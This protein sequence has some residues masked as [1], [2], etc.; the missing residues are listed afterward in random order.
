MARVEELTWAVAS[1][2][3]TPSRLALRTSA[4]QAAVPVVAVAATADRVYLAAPSGAVGAIRYRPRACPL[5]RRLIANVPL[6]R[7]DG[8]DPLDDAGASV[9]VPV[10]II[11]ADL[12]TLASC[13]VSDDIVFNAT[14]PGSWP[15]GPDLADFIMEAVP[16]LGLDADAD[17]L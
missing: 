15:S 17:D 10:D 1:E 16:G 5:F 11:E 2:D 14:Y 4:R 13:T 6:V 7:D 3:D 8:E 12:R 9:S